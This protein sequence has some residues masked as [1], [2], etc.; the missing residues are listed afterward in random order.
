MIKFINLKSIKFTSLTYHYFPSD[1]LIDFCLIKIWSNKIYKYYIKSTQYIYKVIQCA[2]G[3]R[4]QRDL[5]FPSK[6]MADM[7]DK[8]VCDVF[9]MR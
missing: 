5:C 9:A 6:Y 2:C 8:A 3:K 4:D 1:K 7:F